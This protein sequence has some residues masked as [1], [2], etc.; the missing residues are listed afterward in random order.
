MGDSLSCSWQRQLVFGYCIL[1]VPL[2]RLYIKA[3]YTRFA[4]VP[5]SSLTLAQVLPL[6]YNLPQRTSLAPMPRSPL[7]PVPV[8]SPAGLLYFRYVIFV[9][10]SEDVPI[11][12][13]DLSIHAVRL[14]SLRSQ[15]TSVKTGSTEQRHGLQGL[16]LFILDGI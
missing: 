2:W 7:A 12:P 16:S 1:S 9:V 6:P 15:G 14:S 13:V 4:S 11:G 8:Q 3:S 5:V 10:T